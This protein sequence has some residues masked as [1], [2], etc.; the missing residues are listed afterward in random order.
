MRAIVA[1]RRFNATGCEFHSAPFPNHLIRSL[2]RRCE[3]S[4]SLER[5]RHASGAHF[6]RRLF[7]KSQPTGRRAP[8]AAAKSDFAVTS[9]NG[10]ETV[11]AIRAVDGCGSAWRK[12]PPESWRNLITCTLS[13]GVAL[14]TKESC[15]NLSV[16]SSAGWYS[17][18]LVLFVA[19]CGCTIFTARTAA[20]RRQWTGK[21]FAAQS[22]SVK[23]NRPGR[24]D[25]DSDLLQTGARHSEA[26]FVIFARGRRGILQDNEDNFV[27]AGGYFS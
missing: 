9:H 7:A 26:R 10:E 11:R 15:K 6:E 24:D 13:D 27:T 2:F 14:F 25:R 4:C 22:E 23:C 12:W 16:R 18:W 3:I 5:L 21:A 1:L 8:G 20:V 17:P 19:S